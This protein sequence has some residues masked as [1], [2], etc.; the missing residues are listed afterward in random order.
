MTLTVTELVL[1]TIAVLVLLGLFAAQR[2]RVAGANEALVISGARGSKVRDDKGD[3]VTIHDQGVKVVVGAGTFTWPLI[4][5]VGRLQLTARQGYRRARG[6]KESGGGERGRQHPKGRR[7]QE[8][9]GKKE[10]AAGG[11]HPGEPRPRVR[12][13]RSAKGDGESAGGGGPIGPPRASSR[14]ERR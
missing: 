13:G 3:L 14:H 2:Y 5:K 8:A 11:H 9:G 10:R 4:N 6:E 1:A 12:T 7:W